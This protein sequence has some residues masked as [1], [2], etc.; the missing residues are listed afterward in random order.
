[1][2]PMRIVM[3]SLQFATYFAAA[4]VSETDYAERGGTG[5]S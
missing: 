1:M 5:P 3:F 2:P 4:N